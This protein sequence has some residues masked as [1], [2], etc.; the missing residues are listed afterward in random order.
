MSWGRGSP[1]ETSPLPVVLEAAHYVELV[2]FDPFAGRVWDEI[3][4][5]NLRE[6]IL[7]T[8]DRAH[9]ILEKAGDHRVEQVRLRRL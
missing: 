7:P 3:N 2:T 8:R 1:R 4:G 6:N 5:A 9:L